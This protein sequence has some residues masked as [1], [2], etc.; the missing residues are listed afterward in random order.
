MHECMLYSYILFHCKSIFILVSFINISHSINETNKL[1]RS[2]VLS[3]W[4]LCVCLGT[5]ALKYLNN[6]TA[7]T[8]LSDW[9]HPWSACYVNALHRILLVL[10]LRAALYV[11]I[12]LLKVC[13]NCAT[14][15]NTWFTSDHSPETVPCVRC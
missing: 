14:Y 11:R 2:H 7:Y 13:Y 6:K 1:T 10:I 3:I 12:Y 9:H 15:H 4:S 5:R 8:I